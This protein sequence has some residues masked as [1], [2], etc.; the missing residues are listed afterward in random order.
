[1][2]NL[3]SSSISLPS[4]GERGD[5][6][7]YIEQVSNIPSLEAEEEVELAN[8]FVLYKDI[9]AAQR[10]VTSHLKLV[11]KIAYK[12]KGYGLPLGELI[13]EGNFGLMQAVKRFNPDLGYRLSTYATWWIKA[14]MQ[15][16]VIRTWSLVKIGTTAAQKKLFFNLGKLK[17]RILGAEMSRTLRKEEI[18][19]IATELNVTDEEVS[20]MEQRL[21]QNDL[22]LN[23]KLGD[24]DDNHREALDYIQESRPNQEMML[25]EKEDRQNRLALLAKAMEFLNDREKKIIQARRLS[26]S[27]ITL[28]D[29][30]KE[31]E[32]STERVRQIEERAIEKLRSAMLPQYSA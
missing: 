6:Y 25:V 8:K 14:A 22:S 10:L 28:A 5:L 16:Y 7:R 18:R 13:S 15:E 30:G 19:M 27:P 23:V 31:L 3:V 12:F 4:L 32:I 29:L 11:V 17:R 24:S 2:S 21:G 9:E 20:E 1:M 26:E